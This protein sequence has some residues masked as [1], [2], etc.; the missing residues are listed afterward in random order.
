MGSPDIAATLGVVAAEALKA[1][2]YQKWY[3][4][5]RH[6]PESGGALVHFAKTGQGNTVEGL[7]SNTVLNSQAVSQ[8]LAQNNSYFLS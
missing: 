7:P 6:R 2:W 5:L 4:H 3:I 1:V 8:A